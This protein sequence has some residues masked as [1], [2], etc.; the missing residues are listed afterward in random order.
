MMT[1]L[2]STSVCE[3]EETHHFLAQ[4]KTVGKKDGAP[5]TNTRSIV[6]GKLALAT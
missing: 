6:S 3:E 1:L 4:L 2:R 5:T